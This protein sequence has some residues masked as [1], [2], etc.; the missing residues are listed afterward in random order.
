MQ[1]PDFAHFNVFLV[2]S[3]VD[4]VILRSGFNTIY[5]VSSFLRNLLPCAGRQFR[6]R[7]ERGA[8]GDALAEMDDSIGRVVSALKRADVLNNTLIVFT[9]DNG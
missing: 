2:S 9:A 3:A 5:S 4:Y 7:T 8:F 6:N 1:M